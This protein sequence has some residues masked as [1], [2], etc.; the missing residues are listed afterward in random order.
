MVI[1][2]N[3]GTEVAKLLPV[4]LREF[5]K[6]Q[7]DTFSQGFLAVLTVPQIVVLEFL[8]EKGPC[9]MNELAR[10]LNFTMSAGTAIV[11]KMIKLNLVKRERS[12]EDR[13]VVTVMILDKGKEAVKRV[14]EARRNCI[15]KMFSGLTEKDR[16]EYLRILTKIYHNLTP[17]Q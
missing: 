5:T 1:S 15:N 17:G 8:Y 7:K 12:S 14:R 13:R 11:D 9:Q 6:R 4:I 3:F 10:A 2:K 16:A